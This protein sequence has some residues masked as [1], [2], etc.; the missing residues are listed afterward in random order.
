MPNQHKPLPPVADMEQPLRTY[1]DLSLSDKEIA[2][3]LTSHYDTSQY[4]C[5]YI[6]VRRLRKEWGLKSTRQQKHTSQSIEPF[7]KEIK[8]KFPHHGILAVWKNLRQEFNVRASENTVK[9]LL[10]QLEPDAMRARKGK[11][12]HRT[13]F[14]AAGV[15]NCW[16]QDQHDKWGPRFGLWLHN[17]IYPFIAFNNWLKVWHT[18]KNPHL[19]TKYFLDM[20]LP[21]FTQIDP[22]NENNGVAN[23]QTIMRQRLDPNLAGT[24]QHKW[25][26]EKNNVKNEGNWSVMRADLSPGLED[27]F[28][29]GLQNGWY[30]VGNPLENLVF[31]WLA[32]PFVQI[33]LDIWVNHHNKTKPRR[34]KH[35]VLP[36]GIPELLRTKPNFYG[37]VDFKIPVSSQILDEMEA[38]FA[39]P[40]HEVFQLVPPEFDHWAN[41]YYDSMERPVVQHKT[42]W[43]I[44]R[45]LLAYFTQVPD[46]EV[47]LQ[48]PLSSHKETTRRIDEEEVPLL[49]GQQPL[50]RVAEIY[51]PE[52][53]S[54]STSGAVGVQYGTPEYANFTSSEDDSDGDDDG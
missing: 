34:D 54:S 3:H 42:F 17:S 18:N 27:L 16:G 53:A 29:F 45:Q 30:D 50:R 13:K 10:R 31:R 4:G 44:Y 22:G 2:Q 6:S 5:S 37:L 52:T 20:S 28:E 12:F 15:D 43:D 51:R 36:H 46:V 26:T 7:V 35:K 19:I 49:P 25:M 33:Q 1:F 48:I 38:R 11:K 32:I 8:S 39:P 21:V 24:L 14:Y 23:V 47:D 9:T 41:I 40:D